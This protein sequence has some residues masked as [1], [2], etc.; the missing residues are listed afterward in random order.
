METPSRS[1]ENKA[2]GDPWS[3][4]R[5]S[6][7]LAADR[8]YLYARA[9]SAEGDYAASAELLEQT[10]DLAADWAPLWLALAE[11]HEKLGDLNKAKTALARVR[12]LDPQGEFGAD[13]H[14]ARLGAAPAPAA[15]P[16]AYVQGLFDQYADRFDDH[17]VETLAYRGPALLSD[18]LTGLGLR[19]FGHVLD[20]GCGTGLCGAAFRRRSGRLTGVDLSPRMV[21][22][23]RRKQIYDRLEICSIDDFLAREPADSAS[24]VLAADVFVYFGDLRPVLSAAR[25][26]LE[27][28]GHLAFTLQNGAFAETYRVG[29]DLRYAHSEAFVRAATGDAGLRI[30]AIEQAALRRDVG[31]DVPGL[32]VAAARI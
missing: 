17:I 5:S 25:R 6:G 21:A 8:R 23:A 2:A 29:S 14:L 10:T 27:P 26:V 22:L 12:A 3:V 1:E 30:A 19:H 7:N 20:L 32:I 4:A 11:A 16:G 13:L 18:A 28:R 9:A 24:L 15:A 31:A